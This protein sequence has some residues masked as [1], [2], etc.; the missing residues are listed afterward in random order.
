[1]IETNIRGLRDPFVLVEDGTYYVY[2]TGVASGWVNSTYDCYKSRD[3]LYG[4]WE[5]VEL[6]ENK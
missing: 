1:M 3:G 6:C 4:E 2:G 5:K